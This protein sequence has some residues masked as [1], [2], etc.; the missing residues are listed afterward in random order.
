MFELLE[1]IEYRIA[2]L[3]S[4]APSTLNLVQRLTQELYRSFHSIYYLEQVCADA[5]I[6][7]VRMEEDQRND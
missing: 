1:G 3:L 2:L 4:S 6:R 5:V 7:R